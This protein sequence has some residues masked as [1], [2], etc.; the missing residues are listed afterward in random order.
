MG[1]KERLVW[2]RERYVKEAIKE[3][4]LRQKKRCR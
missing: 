1:E 4:K 3:N 2:F